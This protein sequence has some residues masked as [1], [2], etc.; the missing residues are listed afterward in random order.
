MDGQRDFNTQLALV[1]YLYSKQGYA[2]EALLVMDPSSSR[3]PFRLLLNSTNS[4]YVLSLLENQGG[5]HNGKDDCRQLHG[6][7]LD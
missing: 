5:S 1:R 7:G 2:A 6:G 4:D 3:L